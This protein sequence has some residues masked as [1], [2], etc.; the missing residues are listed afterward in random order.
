MN[1]DVTGALFTLI[2]QY[3]YT[4]TQFQEGASDVNVH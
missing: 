2:F 1:I 3:E 4:Q